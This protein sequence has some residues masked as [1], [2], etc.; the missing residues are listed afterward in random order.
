[1]GWTWDYV[2]NEMDLVRLGHLGR[3]WQASP[4]VHIAV[5]AY[6]GIGKEQAAQPQPVTDTASNILDAL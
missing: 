4:P 5:A 2:E 1:M 3:Y 6:L